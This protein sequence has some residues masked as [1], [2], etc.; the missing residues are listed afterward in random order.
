M[1]EWLSEAE[2]FQA[3]WTKDASFNGK[4]VVGVHSTG[5]YCLPS[6][7]ARTPKPENVK[8]YESFADARSAGLRACKRCRPEEFERGQNPDLE[9][10]ELE[11]SEMS[12]GTK[13]LCTVKELAAELGW[14]TSKVQDLVREHFQVSPQDLLAEISMSRARAL[15]P[16]SSVS[17]VAAELG[18]ESPASFSDRFA[19][20][21][22]FLPSHYSKVIGGCAVPIQVPAGFR[23]DLLRQRLERDADGVL[24]RFDGEQY[25][26]ALQTGGEV[27]LVHLNLGH[28]LTVCV[29]GAAVHPGLDAISRLLGLAQDIE[30]FSRRCRQLAVSRLTESREGARIPLT[31][32]VFDSVLWAII[33]QQMNLAFTRR[34][35]ARLAGALS[36]KTES[37]LVPLPLPAQIVTLSVED[38]LAMQFS[39]AKADCLLRICST[40]E[41]LGLES[42][43]VALSRKLERLM[44]VKGIGVWTTNYV[45]LRGLG[46]MD[47]APIG[48]TGLVAGLRT[49]YE[50][51]SKPDQ[52]EQ[53]RLMEP[54]RPFR[55]LATYHLWSLK[56]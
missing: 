25:Q 14:G 2:K 38:L 3:H 34:V 17:E 24:S 46:A 56:P 28:H 48:D 31:A 52:D 37:G 42:P 41:L 54:F 33:G 36:E 23:V 30:G 39:K 7:K 5:I 12:N 45:A 44:A 55:S 15:L 53:R 26:F 10:L 29:E 40:Y 8:F 4:F 11:L 21:T 27:L 50:L 47:A 18:Y 35:L 13:P 51:P 19:Q 6:C 32:T 43:S 20:L 1:S 9:H 22:G 16:I 49:L